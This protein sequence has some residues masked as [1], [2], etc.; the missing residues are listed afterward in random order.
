ML[1]VIKEFWNDDKGDGNTLSQV[2]WAIAVLG[3][4]G[5]V[6]SIGLVGLKN[7]GFNF[8]KDF[9]SY[10]VVTPDSIDI[11]AASPTTTAEIIDG[12]TAP[13]TVTIKN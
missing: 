2:G 6:T 4:V 11:N 7:K 9:T 8:A 1:N 10:K 12:T 13:I 5:L 3:A